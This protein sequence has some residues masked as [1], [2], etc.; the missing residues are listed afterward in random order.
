MTVLKNQRQANRFRR[1]QWSTKHWCLAFLFSVILSLLLLYNHVT[2]LSAVF[3]NDDYHLWLW[4]VWV[5]NE[6][7][8]NGQNP[9][10]TDLVFYPIGANLGRHALAPGFVPITFAVELIAA[11]DVLYPV[12]AYRII[13]LISFSLM[14]TFG[15][16]TLRELG[17][18]FWSALVAA[19]GYSFCDFYML[20]W[21]HLH[22]I[23][24]FFI[25]MTAYAMVRLYK[26]P[27]TA[28]LL[29]CAFLFGS[30]IY[31]TEFVIYMCMGALLLLFALSL[32]SQERSSLCEKVREVGAKGV[33]ACLLAVFLLVVPFVLNWFSSDALPPNP[34]AHSLYSSNLVG[35]FVPSHV[36]TPL[37]G[38]LFVSL[39]E[40]ITTGI[41]GFEIFIGYPMIVFGVV[42]LFRAKHRLVFISVVLALAFF[43][44]SLGPTLKVASTDTGI[45][46]PYS[47][48]ATV[49]PFN[50]GRTPVRAVVMGMFFWMIVA[51]YGMES[52]HRA[53]SKRWGT[54]VSSGVMMMVLLW[55]VA[56]VYSPIPRQE[57]FHIPKGLDRIVSG[58]VFNVP[59]SSTTDGYAQLLQVFHHQ[60]I[61]SGYLSRFS[62]RQIKYLWTLERLLEA[63]T[64][65]C[66]DLVDMGFRNLILPAET[67]R[68]VLDELSSC[69]INVVVMQQME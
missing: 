36:S 67:S 21:V 69:S 3:D 40:R 48:L 15:Y 58:P 68:Y 55:T 17:L 8:T 34:M 5:V 60:P 31:F 57:P 10:L 43:V 33:I 66:P 61:A 35:F 23:A 18:G 37:Y 56:E 16:L 49:P 25:P 12:Y 2:P 62:E 41:A 19:I 1:I 46:M 22:Q 26:R 54:Y 42:S 65:S 28:N 29:I 27:T 4:N 13:I 45:P 9:Y 30:A 6:L 14:L 63:G 24:G 32:L 52:V 44:L 64:Q 50:M 20:H 51:A 53:V 47:L 39:E 59:L 11:G 38:N 7:V